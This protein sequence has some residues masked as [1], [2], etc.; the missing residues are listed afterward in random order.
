MVIWV[1]T[2]ECC[3]ERICDVHRAIDDDMPPSNEQYDVVTPNQKRI[4]SVMSLSCVYTSMLGNVEQKNVFPAQNQGCGMPRHET[5]ICKGT[6]PLC[7]SVELDSCFSRCYL[8]YATRTHTTLKY[9]TLCSCR[10]AFGG[11]ACVYTSTKISCT[12][13]MLSL[14]VLFYLLVQ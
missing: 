3:R 1:P 9:W 8:I 10:V 11:L 6:C 12:C 5:C 4:L 13:R 2:T 14:C 7:V